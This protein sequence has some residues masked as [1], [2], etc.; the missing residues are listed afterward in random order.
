MPQSERD[1]QI[2][3]T[4]VWWHV[5]P[6]GFLGAERSAADLGGTEVR[7]R[8][9]ALTGWLDYSLALGVEGWVLGPL[10]AS[11]THGYDTTDHFRVDPRL[12]DERDL[13]E[14]L[15]AAHSR[16]LRIVLDGVFNHVGRGFE[17]YRRAVAEGPDSEAARWFQLDW[18]D[19][20]G[21]RPLLFEGH[22]QLVTLA[23]EN[24][25]VVDYVVDVMDHW[26]ARGVA[27]WRLDAAYAA[28][29]AFWQQVTGRIRHAHP[30]CWLFAELIHGD[31][32]EFVAESG[33]DSATQY[34]LWKAIPSSLNDA[35]FFELAHALGRH[36]HYLDSF[37]P[38][39]FLGNHDTTRIASA[40]RDS[41]LLPHALAVLFGVGGTPVVYAGD[42]QGYTGVKYERVGGDD[43][44]RPKFPDTPG[45][46]S[47]LGA[48]L[49]DLYR[50]LIEFR[51]ARPWLVDARTDVVH[52]EN[53][54]AVFVTRAASGTGER[55]A[56]AL[57]LELSP[58]LLPLPAGN[59]STVLGSAGPGPDGVH[60]PA[61]GWALLVE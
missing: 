39:T 58:R 4:G 19:P 33:V 11:E 9:A 59:W 30:D 14:L 20:G 55:L 12:G 38:V 17:Q 6:L 37:A 51:S 56:I 31:Y 13:L 41:D 3:P 45:E 48:K 18:S 10:F 57:N 47:A 32:A 44:V 60:V 28:P 16:G 23:H 8:L 24:P 54:T 22:D 53:T 36:D 27:G 61:K 29:T 42:E 5:Y 15:D 52:L 7:H 40:L 34:E 43:E 50:A 25:A 46:F 49:F 1:S 35:N 21:P 2:P 26:C